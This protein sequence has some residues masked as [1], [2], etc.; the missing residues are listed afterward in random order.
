[1]NEE[2]L[3][4][5]LFANPEGFFAMCDDKGVSLDFLKELDIPKLIVAKRYKDECTPEF[6]AAADTVLWVSYFSER[7]LTRAI[8]DIEIN[9]GRDL[10]EMQAELDEMVF[11]QKITFADDNYNQSGNSDAYI[12]MLRSI[13]ELRNDMAHGRMDELVYKGYSLGDIKGQMKLVVDLANS[14]LNR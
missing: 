1:M 14:A 12:K 11:G 6:F 3:K 13:K 8:K 7:E 2:E 4:E 10:N 9:H 5:F